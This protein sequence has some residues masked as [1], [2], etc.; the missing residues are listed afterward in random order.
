MTVAVIAI[1]WLH[2]LLGV[3]WF[4][5]ILYVDIVVIP[6][7]TKLPLQEQ[8]KIGGLLGARSN[9]V[10]VPAGILVVALGF[11][12]GAVF[13]HLQSPSDVFG[14]A[15]GIT[16]LISLL[17]TTGLVLFGLL[18]I[19]PRTEALSSAKSPDEYSAAMSRVR[20]VTLIELVAFIAIFTCMILMRF[21]Y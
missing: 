5:S 4:G 18:V 9:Q 8:Q 15:Y 7:L 16:W 20:V 19:A 12:R 21:G 3:F 13:G 14:S 17:L 1:Q 11:L 10:L 2:V 6:S